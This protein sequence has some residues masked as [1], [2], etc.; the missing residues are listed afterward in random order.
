MPETNGQQNNE[1]RL[2]RIEAAMEAMVGEHE[3]F[4]A[5]HK[6]LLRSQVLLQDSLEK[7]KERIDEIGGKLDALIDVVDRNS[8]EFRD[9]P[10]RLESRN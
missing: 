3:V 2:D 6:M 7:Q 5:E 8:R 10:N 1:S 4:R 9:R